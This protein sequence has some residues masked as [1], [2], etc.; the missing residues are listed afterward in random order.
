MDFDAMSKA[1]RDAKVNEPNRNIWGAPNSLTKSSVLKAPDGY[2]QE[3]E[4]DYSIVKMPNGDYVV[5]RSERLGSLNYDYVC[6]CKTS[7]EAREIVRALNK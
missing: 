4:V 3:T 2:Y 6:T 1:Y 5:A 7:H